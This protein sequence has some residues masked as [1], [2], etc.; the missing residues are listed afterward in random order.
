M[1]SQL[2][3]FIL[4]KSKIKST[5]GKTQPLLIVQRSSSMGNKN[6]FNENEDIMSRPSYHE[7]QCR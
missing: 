6:S 7:V 1:I 5:S 2:K 4:G 3:E